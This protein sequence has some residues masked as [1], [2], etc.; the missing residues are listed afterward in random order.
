MIW[1]AQSCCRDRSRSPTLDQYLQVFRALLAVELPVNL[2]EADAAIWFSL[3]SVD[4]LRAHT[5]ALERLSRSKII[6]QIFDIWKTLISQH[7]HNTAQISTYL[8]TSDCLYRN[9]VRVRRWLTELGRRTL[10]GS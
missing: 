8:A 9:L 4:S 10:A 2:G 7:S 3:F 6:W 1:A 5:E